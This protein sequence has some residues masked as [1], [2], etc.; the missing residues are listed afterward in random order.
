MAE[1]KVVGFEA[2]AKRAT[3]LFMRTNKEHR[4]VFHRFSADYG[5]HR[6]QHRMLMYICNKG[7]GLS[8]KQLAE[9]MDV[10]PAAIT[11][12]LNKL[13]IGGYIYRT[14]YAADSRVNLI[15]PTE[16]GEQLAA[17]SRKFFEKI[18]KTMFD[19]FDEETLVLLGDL[20]ER[21]QSNLSKL[22]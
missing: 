3:K 6:S 22:G 20:F 21:M 12:M 15:N 13:E 5:M 14:V 7:G 4:A 17:E 18:D 16:K 19:G 11:V 1:D 2:A 8:Q 9:A 10:S